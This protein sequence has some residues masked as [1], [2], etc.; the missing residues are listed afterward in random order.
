[1]AQTIDFL[2][3]ALCLLASIGFVIKI[4]TISH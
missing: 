2:G 3:S 1:M 4:N